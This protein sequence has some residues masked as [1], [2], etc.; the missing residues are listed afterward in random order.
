MRFGSQS[1]S[2]PLELSSPGKTCLRRRR[3]LN[4]LFLLSTLTHALEM[5][6]LLGEDRESNGVI[7]Q[8]REG[9]EGEECCVCDVRGRGGEAQQTLENVMGRGEI[10]GEGEGRRE[11]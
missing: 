8:R 9:E 1:E 3:R 10:W 6:D 5:L 7:D 4:I 11:K 2:D